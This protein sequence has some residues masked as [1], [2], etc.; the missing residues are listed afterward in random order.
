MHGAVTIPE[1]YTT[2]F[3]GELPENR[4]GL[5]V[6]EG[7]WVEIPEDLSLWPEGTVAPQQTLCRSTTDP[8]IYKVFKY[9]SQ[10]D[11]SMFMPTGTTYGGVYTRE[12]WERFVRDLPDIKAFHAIKGNDRPGA[13]DEVLRSIREAR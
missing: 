6:D 9:D 10:I 12:M 3:L 2:F 4:E 8:K 11:R 1:M 7:A 13:M 5:K